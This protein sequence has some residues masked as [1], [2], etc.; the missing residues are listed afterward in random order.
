MPE[1]DRVSLRLVCAMAVPFKIP[2]K[3]HSSDSC[4]LDMQSPLSRLQDINSQKPQ[5]GSGDPN[6]RIPHKSNP[7]GSV[8]SKDS[9]R[10]KSAGYSRPLT[11]GG[12]RRD[13]SSHGRITHTSSHS[14]PRGATRPA[15]SFKLNKQPIKIS[16]VQWNGTPG[17][18]S[19]QSVFR[20]QSQSPAAGRDFTGNCRWRPKRAS[21][22]LL[23]P[24]E[25]H[26]GELGS[27]SFKIHKGLDPGELET[28]ECS[29]E[30]EDSEERQSCSQ[31]K[32][33][34]MQ[35]ISEEHKAPISCVSKDALKMFKNGVTL[36][37][38]TFSKSSNQNSSLHQGSSIQEAPAKAFGERDARKDPGA[39]GTPE[40]KSKDLPVSFYSRLRRK[41]TYTRAKPRSIE[42]IVLSSDEEGVEEINDVSGS[43]QEQRISEGIRDAQLQTKNSKSK[44]GDGSRTK[45]GVPSIMELEFTRLHYDTVKAQANG[46]IV[47]TEDSI[48][49]PLK[50]KD[51]EGEDNVCISCSELLSYGL[52]DGA[53]A[54]D[55]TLL[56]AEEEPAPSL[57][58]LMVSESQARLLQK[59]LCL[60]H[61]RQTS[62]ATCPFFLLVLGGQ[63]EDLQKA[64]LA[65]LMD[66]IGLRFD[67]EALSN[68]LPWAEGLRRLHC[69]PRG[70][71]FLLLLG[72]NITDTGRDKPEATGSNGSRP[73]QTCSPFFSLLAFYELAQRSTEI[74]S[75]MTLPL[76]KNSSETSS[77][78]KEP[79]ARR[80]L[81]SHSK[82]QRTP[83]RLIQYP[84]PPS[85][86]GITVT[87]EDLECLKEGEFLN[88]VIIDF[89]LKYLLLE[90]ADKDAAE[91]SHVFSSFFYKQLTRKD[92]RGPQET[93][94]TAAHRRHQRVRTWTRH[95]DIFSKDFLFIPVN[96]EAHWY[97]AVICFPALEKPECVQWRNKGLV[98]QDESQTSSAGS[99]GHSQPEIPLKSTGNVQKE[100]ENCTEHNC[101][102]EMVCR[103]PCILLMDSLK[104][105]YH[106]HVCTLLREYL[107]V[108]W[109]LRKGS[110]R[111]FSS[112]KVTGSHCRVPQQDNSSDCGLYLLHYVQS[113]L[114]VQWVLEHTPDFLSRARIA[115][116]D[117]CGNP[118]VHFDLPLRLEH[119]FP[120]S[121]VRR[122]RAELRELVVELYRKQGG[123]EPM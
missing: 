20:P 73:P 50:G 55:G 41:V 90:K 17:K 122:K 2:K 119:W 28:I 53:F 83:R 74:E 71:N 24:D 121:E 107:Q 120:R 42:P 66:L 98:S 15:F 81:R 111:S 58:F 39:S 103:R 10:S 112:E 69:H 37:E 60:F 51:G 76:E 118:V 114:E 95:V 78:F 9:D 56:L 23:G 29:H 92:S 113:F 48:S 110:T 32:E 34:R 1:I 47:I 86:G 91:R 89:Y 64:L 14:S 21:D 44:A 25:N 33:T 67:V 26:T 13:T 35:S 94:S 49:I 27:S 77:S 93:G 3:K 59:E 61:P 38:T 7:N 12:E 43:L 109:E 104:L 36:K 97:L 4:S 100:S 65:S 63:L 116:R 22:S 72:Q 70:E 46:T 108:E 11:L 68:A 5:W 102:R 75:P 52:W 40:S 96:H 115:R 16:P 85:K 80:P 123:V 82:Q 18:V 57:L 106:Q 101:T 105:S 45:V 84:P 62:G 88:D 87:T 8:F 30:D 31:V 19:G 6:G 99:T 54:R 117:L 79:T